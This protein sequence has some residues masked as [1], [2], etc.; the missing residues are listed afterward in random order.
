MIIDAE[1][2]KTLAERKALARA[3]EIK[4]NAQ[5]YFEKKKGFADNTANIIR[6]EA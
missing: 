2:I 1:N 4:C 5:A 6:A 3:E